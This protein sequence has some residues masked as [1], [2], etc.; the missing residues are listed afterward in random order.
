MRA[1]FFFLLIQSNTS[2]IAGD[3]TPFTGQEVSD[4]CPHGVLFL[5]QRLPRLSIVYISIRMQTC[6]LLFSLSQLSNEHRLYLLS[7]FMCLSTLYTAI[8]SVLA[9]ASFVS[10]NSSCSDKINQ[11]RTLIRT[12]IK[13]GHMHNNESNCLSVSGMGAISTSSMVLLIHV[14]L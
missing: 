11:E 6:S 9:R 1:L 7:C 2:F 12:N 5:C 8:R 13:R 14:H 4:D 10:V 3:C